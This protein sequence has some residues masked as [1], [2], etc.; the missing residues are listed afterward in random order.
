MNK[1]TLYLN[2]QS[3]I[4]NFQLTAKLFAITL[5]LTSIFALPIYSHAQAVVFEEHVDTIPDQGSFGP[6]KKNFIHL[7]VGLG[8]IVGPAEN[9]GSAIKYGLSSDLEIAYRYKR[10]ISNFYSCG[11]EMGYHGSSFN[12][13]QDAQKTLP[14]AVINKNE[15]FKFYNF[16]MGIYNRFNFGRRGNVIGNYVDI[17]GSGEFPFSLVHITRNDGADGTIVRTLTSH[18]NYVNKFNYYAF[19]RLGSNRYA[20]KAAYRLSDLFK[21]N[22]NY[23]ELPKIAMT[24]QVGIH[25]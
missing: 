10:K 20:L 7:F 15:L 22:T 5:L 8:C 6:N 17:G 3:T 16:A 1:F 19:I 18:L 21:K 11:T 23:A 25:K 9:A 2:L 14:N 24:L 4:F 12:L 13:K